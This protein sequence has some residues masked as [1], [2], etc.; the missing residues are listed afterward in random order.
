MMHANMSGRQAIRTRYLGPTNFRGAR[1]RASAEAGSVTV[2]WDYALNVSDNH[3]CAV[4]RL[5]SVLGWS[6]A[7]R[8]GQFGSD[9]YWVSEAQS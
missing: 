1:I 9:Y 8:G 5:Q 7:F 3:A 6:E 2:A 4:L